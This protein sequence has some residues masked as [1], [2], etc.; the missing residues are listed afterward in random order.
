MCINHVLPN[1]C[2]AFLYLNIYNEYI[3]DIAVCAL[4]FIVSFCS[5]LKLVSKIMLHLHCTVLY[6]YYSLL[7]LSDYFS[8]SHFQPIYLLFICPF[9]CVV[10]SPASL[11]HFSTPSLSL[12]LLSFIV[13]PVLLIFYYICLIAFC[14]AIVLLQLSFSHPFQS[15][16]L[17]L[18]FSLIISLIIYCESAIYIYMLC[19]CMYLL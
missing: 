9:Y 3:N 11:S 7:T 2:K 13:L 1:S 15:L 17:F 10:S 8:S 4:E 19:F 14:Y 18:F 12:S 16:L 5:R 6:L